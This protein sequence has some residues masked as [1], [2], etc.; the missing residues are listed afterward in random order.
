MKGTLLGFVAVTALALLSL[1]SADVLIIFNL[2]NTESSV[3]TKRKWHA[4]YIVPVR[5]APLRYQRNGTYYEP[6][7]KHAPRPIRLPRPTS[8]PHRRVQTARVFVPPSTERA[9]FTP[10]AM[11]PGDGATARV[12]SMDA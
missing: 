8:P 9:F 1:A 7:V 3:E 4:V 11:C 5:D 12:D 6:Q 2:R 10:G